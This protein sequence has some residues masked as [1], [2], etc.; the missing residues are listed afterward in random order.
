MQHKRE[1]AGTVK[2]IHL[3]GQRKSPGTQG[4]ISDQKHAGEKQ[5]WKT[6]ARTQASCAHLFQAAQPL[7][8]FVSVGTSASFPLRCLSFF[9]VHE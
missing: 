8:Y 4:G 5:Q 9:R 7:D 6:Q 3:E 1:W 2:E